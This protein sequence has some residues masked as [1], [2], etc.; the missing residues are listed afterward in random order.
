MVFGDG[1]GQMFGSFTQSLDVIAHELTHGVTQ[2]TASLP[3]HQQAGALNES[4]SDVFGTM[5]KQYTK[6]ETVK[7]ADWLICAELLMPAIT[8]T[9]QFEICETRVPPMRTHRSV[10]THS[11]LT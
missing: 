11:L 9:E 10:A 6:N 3:Y 7:Q 8:A 2:Y 5:V 4:M 1:D